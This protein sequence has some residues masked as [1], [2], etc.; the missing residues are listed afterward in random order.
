[1]LSLNQIRNYFPPFLRERNEFQKY[2]LKEY[3]QLLI[4]DFLSTSR[5]IKK[6][7]FIV[8]TNL[9]LVKGIDRF[10][11]DID[12]DCKELSSDEFSIMGEEIIRYLQMQGFNV[13]TTQNSGLKLNTFRLNLYFPELL[14]QLGLSKHED[15][16]FLIK[17]ESQNQKILYKSK[18]IQIKGCGFYF[19]FPTPTDNVLCAMKISALI[20]RSKGRDFYDT[21]FMLS[22]TEPDYDFLTIKCGVSN[23]EELVKTLN[24][25]LGKIDLQKKSKDF[26]HLLLD[27]KKNSKILYFAD[28]IKEI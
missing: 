9:R 5:W 4:L 7:I 8:G 11:E 24:I 20:N 26:E 28:F 25:L 23:K 14:F 27:R 2:F 13:K 21:I 6:L 1:M 16:R 10:S 22:Q 19:P 3:I 15:E 18:I 12:F 17:I